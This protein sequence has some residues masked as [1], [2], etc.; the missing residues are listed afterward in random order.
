MYKFSQLCTNPKSVKKLSMLVT[1]L[2]SCCKFARMSSRKNP[3][4][5][6]G[7]K[8]RKLVET[9]NSS[10]SSGGICDVKPNKSRKTVCGPLPNTN[11][12]Y[13]DEAV[14]HLTKKSGSTLGT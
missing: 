8:K 6:G 1:R 10:Q 3:V 9:T 5:V 7:G 11:L 14:N 12:Q 2:D 4:D 13:W